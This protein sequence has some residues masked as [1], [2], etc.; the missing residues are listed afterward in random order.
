MGAKRKEVLAAV[1]DAWQK[2][3]G[4]Y[5]VKRGVI[6][7]TQ[8]P[9][10]D[11][12]R[13]VAVQV[14]E[15]SLPQPWPNKL[16]RP[17]EDMELSFEIAWRIPQSADDQIDDGTTEAVVEDLRDVLL[18]L[19]ARR[20]AQGNT[21]T[22]LLVSDTRLIEFHDITYHIQGLIVGPITLRY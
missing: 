18:D 6:D 5:F 3:G 14:D 21:L 20:T 11:K 4:V 7:W 19:E 1:K 2:V 15:S 12:P 17:F 9:F 10:A 8:H 13:A 16:S 22:D